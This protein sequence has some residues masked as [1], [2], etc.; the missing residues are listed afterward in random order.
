MTPLE[1]WYE[2]SPKKRNSFNE[3]KNE[4]FLTL[5]NNKEWNWNQE[6]WKF[7]PNIINQQLSYPQSEQNV[8]ENYQ[9]S[10][11]E[12]PETIETQ[13]YLKDIAKRLFPDHHQ[14]IDNVH[15]LIRDTDKINAFFSH[16]LI[17]NQQIIWI[18]KWLFLS[19][20]NETEL[21]FILW[22]ELTHLWFYNDYWDHYN[23]ITEERSSDIRSIFALFDA[24]YDVSKIY[25]FVIKITNPYKK[26][27]FQQIVVDIFWVHGDVK[28]RLTNIEACIAWLDHFHGW[29]DGENSKI[30]TKFINEVDD[31]SFVSHFQETLRLTDYWRLS[32]NEQITYV[33]ENVSQKSSSEYNKQYLI[34]LIWLIEIN[35]EDLYIYYEL[36]NQFI[37]EDPTPYSKELLAPLY[38]YLKKTFKRLSSRSEAIDLITDVF[39][40]VPIAYFSED[41]NKSSQKYRRRNELDRIIKSLPETTDDSDITRSYQRRGSFV[42]KNKENLVVQHFDQIIYKLYLQSVITFSNNHTMI[43]QAFEEIDKLPSYYNFDER[44]FTEFNYIFAEFT[45]TLDDH[46]KDNYLIKASK[47]NLTTSIIPHVCRWFDTQNSPLPIWTLSQINRHISDFI[48]VKDSY[49]ASELAEN[50]VLLVRKLWISEKMLQG[51]M[52]DICNQK[53]V[54]NTTKTTYHLDEWRNWRR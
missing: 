45:T 13:K 52:R 8:C 7:K 11:P 23:S 3:M 14:H 18:S 40:Q 15:F 25:N 39:Q 53:Y 9:L 17:E 48:H 35:D 26:R 6:D 51:V 37:Q 33:K 50:I 47:L 36:L 43:D 28:Q 38:K 16:K 2:E 5:K 54:H 21:A 22:H 27:D 12:D 10:Y 19:A 32:T 31:F 44:K 1:Q 34:T 4:P 46:D 49:Q 24:G 20:D 30:D 41:D 42:E 29:L